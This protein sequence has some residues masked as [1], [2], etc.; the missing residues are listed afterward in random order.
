[1]LKTHDCLKVILWIVITFQEYYDALVSEASEIRL[2]KFVLKEQ[3]L[4]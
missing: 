3:L 4:T 1:M 2:G